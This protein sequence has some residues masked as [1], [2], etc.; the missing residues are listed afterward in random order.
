MSSVAKERP[1]DLRYAVETIELMDQ[2]TDQL[3]D[4]WLELAVARAL[5]EGRMRVTLDDAMSTLSQAVNQLLA[6]QH[7][8]TTGT[9]EAP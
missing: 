8:E 3:Y 4:A 5:D 2:T 7:G 6:G 1:A 9:E